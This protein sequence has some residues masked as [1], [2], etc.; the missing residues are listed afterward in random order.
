MKLENK[1]FKQLLKETK[2]KK[3]EWY[4]VGDITDLKKSDILETQ[5]EEGTT[6]LIDYGKYIFSINTKGQTYSLKITGSKIYI[7]ENKKN[8]Y[9]NKL[10]KKIRKG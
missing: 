7:V 6:S 10:V 2:K 8:K 4:G 1:I 5:I 3:I 9:L